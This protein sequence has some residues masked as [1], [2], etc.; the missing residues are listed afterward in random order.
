M[1]IVHWM[2]IVRRLLTV[3]PEN[4]ATVLLRTHCDRSDTCKKPG[5]AFTMEYQIPGTDARTSVVQA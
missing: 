4:K 5:T 3:C 2:F 1:Q